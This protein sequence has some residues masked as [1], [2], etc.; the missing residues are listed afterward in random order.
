[1][2]IQVKEVKEQ[3]RQRW[4]ESAEEF[5]QCPGPGIHSEREK[6]AWQAI[7]VN[8]VGGKQLKILDVGTGTGFIALLL[9]EYG[10]SVTGVDL[11]EEM[12]A[13]ARDKAKRQKLKVKFQYGDADEL[14]F[15]DNV[16]DAVI[17]RHVFWTM[18]DPEKAA[19]EWARVLKPGGKLLIIDG[20]WNNFSSWKKIWKAVATITVGLTEGVDSS[21]KSHGL[22]DFEKELPLRS[23][24]RPEADLR[25]LRAL[26]MKEAE[27]VR[28]KDPRAHGLLDNLKYGYYQRFVVT[29]I[30]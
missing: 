12:L 4:N 18:S 13:Q 14:P 23:Q 8:A 10:H 30:K 6:K 27:M 28:F 7:L 20:D 19:A 24:K 22:R 1:M 9:A 21:T 16:F 17:N 15:E 2:S 26:G 29:A 5:D 25:I 3:I 11:A